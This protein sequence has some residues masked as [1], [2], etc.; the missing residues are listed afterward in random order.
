M[1]AYSDCRRMIRIGR[2]LHVAF[3]ALCGLVVS[4]QAFAQ[5]TNAIEQVSVTRGASGRTVVRFTLKAPPANPPA[6]FAIANNAGVLSLDATAK[7]FRY[8]DEEEIAR[9]RAATQPKAKK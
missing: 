1:I 9:Q 4:A 6:G 5:A 2:T 7:T 8:L 3:V